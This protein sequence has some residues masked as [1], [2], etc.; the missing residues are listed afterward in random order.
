MKNTNKI[1]ERCQ[2]LLALVLCAVYAQALAQERMALYVGEVKVIRVGSVDRVAVGNGDLLSTSILKNGQLIILAE[3]E[4]ETKLHIWTTDQKER[5]IK[6]L[7]SKGD[8]GRQVSEIQSLLRGL[9]GV[10]VRIV[11]GR[12]VIEGTVDSGGSSLLEAIGGIYKDMINLTNLAQ[13]GNQKMIYMNVQITE[14]NTNRLSELGINWLTNLNGPSG[15]YASENTDNSNSISVLTNAGNPLSVAQGGPITA[16]QSLNYFGIATE[17]TSKINLALNSGDALLL[18]SPVLSARSGGEAE[19]L[20]GGEVPI[21]VSNGLGDTSVEFKEF[22]IILRIKPRADN[23]GNI[24]AEVETELSTVDD[25]LAVNNTPGFRT[26]KTSTDVSLRN[27]QTLILSKLVSNEISKNTTGIIGLS[28][29]PILGALFRS[30]NF[31]NAKSELVIFVTPQ[32]ID[33]DSEVNR[34][35]IARAEELKN[36]F[37]GAVK[38]DKDILD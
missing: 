23:A 6:V 27:G 12:P 10:S 17:I 4:G 8:A 13:V 34:E 25:S 38:K 11:G 3:A 37:F 32:I 22:G 7:I 31:R 18:A 29:I 1:K 19:F 30:S 28:K 5:Q 15:G 33:S 20:S 21:P 26:R 35:S 16:N 2:I 24:V 14:F 36:K 9:P